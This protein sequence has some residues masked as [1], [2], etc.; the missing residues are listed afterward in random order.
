MRSHRLT[1]TLLSA[2][3]VAAGV[4]AHAG[5]AV[6]VPGERSVSC[7]GDWCS[8]QDPERTGCAVGASTVA[9]AGIPWS[10]GLTI[11]LRWSPTCQTNWA[12]VNYGAYT[13][14]RAIQRSTGYTQGASS[15]NGVYWWSAMI[16]SPDKCVY[17]STAGPVFTQ[18]DTW[19]V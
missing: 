7:W 8:G 17:A 12:R 1:L 3:I 5:P 16:Y 19:C 15:N 6:A 11:E 2:C 9:S 10:N 13:Y 14:V 4:L 18:V